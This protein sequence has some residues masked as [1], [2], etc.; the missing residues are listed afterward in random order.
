M[1][2]KDKTPR[3]VVA[4]GGGVNSTAMLVEM[5]RR[6]IRPDLILFA[7]TGGE[8]PETY[9]TVAA[10]SAWCVARGMPPIIIVR[11]TYQGEF[12]SLEAS[13][14]RKSCLPSIAYGFKSCSLKHKVEPQQ[15][16]I[17]NWMPARELWKTGLKVRSAIGYDAGEE[18]RAHILSD[19]K[20]EYWY[21]L[22]EWAIWR[23]SCEAICRSEGLPTAKS[24]CFFCPSMKKHEIFA[25][26]KEHPQL[27]ARA[28]AMEDQAELI[29]VRGLGRH[30]AWRD[31]I[32][33]DEAQLKMFSDAGTPETPCGCYDG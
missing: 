30:Y 14:L 15:K 9:E 22:I 13:C 20:Y 1:K 19:E 23:D 28:L 24:S 6:S 11:A 12:E 26:K 5:H 8:R 18:R 25:L 31:L 2:S 21:P 16:Y 33:N 3:L 29:T 32:Q 17:N 10:V 27:L 4:F 7:D